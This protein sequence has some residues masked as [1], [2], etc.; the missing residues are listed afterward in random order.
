[1][2]EETF[3]IID[4][5]KY[6]VLSTKYRGW[7]YLDVTIKIIYGDAEMVM[8]GEINNAYG[9]ACF[10]SEDGYYLECTSMLEDGLDE[11][12]GEWDD[13]AQYISENIRDYVSHALEESL[14]MEI[15]ENI[16]NY[17]ALA[18]EFNNRSILCK[19]ENMAL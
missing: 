14:E 7:G 18:D 17:E 3:E 16:N 4:N 15:T 12:D 10:Q 13:E 19:L 9:N 8:E 5:L 2:K 11:V 1:M 6:E